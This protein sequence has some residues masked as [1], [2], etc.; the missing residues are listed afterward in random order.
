MIEENERAIDFIVEE[1]KKETKKKST[2]VKP[3]KINAAIQLEQ[4]MERGKSREQLYHE[5]LSKM[6]A[7]KEND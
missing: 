5:T 7:T 2:E 1:F 4:M 3:R 6:L